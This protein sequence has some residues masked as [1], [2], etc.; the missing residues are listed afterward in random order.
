MQN[1]KD[2]EFEGQLARRW[3]TVQPLVSS[4]VRSMIHSF[5]DAEDVIQEVAVAFAESFHRFDPEKSVVPWALSIARHKVV[6]Y[7]RARGQKP[8]AFDSETLQRILHA[9]ESVQDESQE[10][11]LALQSCMKKL[12]DR[13][14]HVVDLRYKRDMSVGDIAQ[15]LGMSD[16][17]VYMMLSRVRTALAKC[18]QGKLRT[19]WRI[20]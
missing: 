15:R 9:Y 5:H 11:Q 14:H 20:A 18:I 19:Q 2:H 4:Y 1:S 7:I 17:A 13:P 12:K 3:T 6:D 16:K 8:A 10:I